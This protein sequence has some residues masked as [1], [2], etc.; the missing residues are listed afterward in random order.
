M[1][2]V[3]TLENEK[4][5]I[6]QGHQAVRREI[7]ETVSRLSPEKRDRVFLGSW[8]VKDLLAHLTGWD[9]TNIAA[10]RAV[11]QGR[12][13]EFYTCRDKDWQT[14]NARLV[15]ENK[16]EGWE[17]MLARVEESHRELVEFMEA[18]STEDFFKDWGVRYKGYKVMIS[19]LV[20]AETKDESVHLVQIQSFL[21]SENLP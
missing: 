4:N 13:P 14:Y 18:L 19:R 12:L 16:L 3:E 5:R 15:K 17:A 20:E 7:L 21:N 1:K 9:F 10:A 2:N 11:K 6:L 8:S